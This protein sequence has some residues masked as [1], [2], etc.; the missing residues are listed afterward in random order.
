MIFVKVNKNNVTTV[1]MLPLRKENVTLIKSNSRV[2]ISIS[3]KK[4]YFLPAY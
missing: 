3:D 2:K 1:N 4:R